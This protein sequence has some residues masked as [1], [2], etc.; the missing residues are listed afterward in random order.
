MCLNTHIT[1]QVSGL[2]FNM[3][4]TYKQCLS[5]MTHNMVIRHK[6]E[7]V[8]QGARDGGHGMSST[9][10]SDLHH[11]CIELPVFEETQTGLALGMALT[12]ANVISIYPRFDFFISGLSQLVNHS[13]KI[14][15]MSGGKFTPNVL[16]RVGVGSKIPLDAGP[17]HT[18]NYSQQLAAMLTEIDVYELSD[19]RETLSTCQ[20]IEES[21]GIRV[22]VEH[23]EHYEK[24]ICG[25]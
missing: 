11:H 24:L 2:I 19:P 7:I 20:K 6:Y 25:N 10:S 15:T 12:G 4:L 5:D 9:I 16:F 18:N 13:D 1:A 3:G 21:K 23:Y 8:G 22:L 17:Q 14:K